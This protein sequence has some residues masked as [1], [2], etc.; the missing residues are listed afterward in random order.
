[1]NNAGVWT[2]KWIRTGDT[3]PIGRDLDLNA[4]HEVRALC[5]GAAIGIAHATKF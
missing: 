2:A 4:S 3:Q 1:M 5:G